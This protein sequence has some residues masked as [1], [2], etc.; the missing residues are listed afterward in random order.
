MPP[1]V[2]NHT[3][4]DSNLVLPN[5]GFEPTNPRRD[6]LHASSVVILA[7]LLKHGSAVLYYT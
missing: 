5:V 1:L 7:S 2:L 4:Q 6:K 3:R